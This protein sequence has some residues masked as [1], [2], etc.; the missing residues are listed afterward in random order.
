MLSISNQRYSFSI[1]RHIPR[2]IFIDEAIL[3]FS[4]PFFF[5][6]SSLFK[7]INHCFSVYLYMQKSQPSLLF[8][9]HFSQRK[10]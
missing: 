2:C 9:T 4:K 10:K 6:G 5:T 3:V 1:S 7:R 8:W